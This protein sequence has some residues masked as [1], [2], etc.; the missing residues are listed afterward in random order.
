ME[1]KIRIMLA[2]TDADP[3]LNS[4]VF[5]PPIGIVVNAIKRRPAEKQRWASIVPLM[6]DKM[7]TVDRE[8]YEGLLGLAFEYE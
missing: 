3:T 7:S 1:E 6:L 2:K 4:G 8:R 5:Q